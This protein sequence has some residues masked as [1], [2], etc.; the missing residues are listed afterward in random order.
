MR[1]LRCADKPCAV[2]CGKRQVKGNGYDFSC[3]ADLCTTFMDGVAAVA[4]GFYLVA[5][6]VVGVFVVRV[7]R[8]TQKRATP[9]IRV[10]TNARHLELVD[11]FKRPREFVAGKLV[12]RPVMLLYPCVKIFAGNDNAF[13]HI[14]NSDGFYRRRPQF[15]SRLSYLVQHGA[16]HRVY[17]SPS[18]GSWL[19]FS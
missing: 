9:E 2:R 10:R 14:G 4:E 5:E 19:R 6:K 1:L 15:V 3:L 18:S 11:I 13:A 7:F 17:I 8:F 12:I 16:W